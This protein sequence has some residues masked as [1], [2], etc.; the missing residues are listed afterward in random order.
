V[1]I[2]LELEVRFRACQPREHA[3]DCDFQWDHY[4]QE[5]TCGAVQRIREEEERKLRDGR[6]L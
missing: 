1:L 4:W 6:H 5:C 2:Q 3:L